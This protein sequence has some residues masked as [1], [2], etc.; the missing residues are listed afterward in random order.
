[1]KKEIIK[2]HARH[3]ITLAAGI[4]LG[5]LLFSSE[6]VPA[7]GEQA[8]PPV[9]APRA[10]TCSMHP[11][12]RQ[13]VPGRCPFCGMDLVPVESGGD[14]S[15]VAGPAAVR[16]SREALALADVSVTRVSETIPVKEISLHGTIRP[17]ERLSRALV[18]H[19]KGRVEQLFVHSPGDSVRRGQPVALLYSPDLLNAQQELLEAGQQPALLAAAREKLRLLKMTGRQIEEI[20]QAGVPSSSVEL[21]ADAGGVVTARRVEVGDYVA[22]GSLLF[23]L[24]GLSPAW[25]IFDARERDLPYLRVGDRVEYVLP[26]LPGRTFQGEITLVEPI[27]D[28]AT[29]ALKV[30]VETPNPSGELKPGMYARATVKATPGTGEARIVIPATAVLWTGR[31]SIA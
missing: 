9:V 24:T 10:W 26:A 16:L 29:R 5:W 7:T 31:R 6:P 3:G 18:A 8:S 1:M 28:E 21:L 2:R 20:R 4:L 25:A 22:P 23:E 13:D 12:V 17:D 19:V 15:P 14:T 27:L 30:R 11:G